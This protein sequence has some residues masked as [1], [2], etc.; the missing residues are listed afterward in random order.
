MNMGQVRQYQEKLKE[1]K[2]LKDAAKEV[3]ADA[4]QLM[5]Q[6]ITEME[7][8]GMQS[9]KNDVGTV[10]L[11]RD[12]YASAAGMEAVEA[13][14]AAELDSLLGVQTGKLK[15]L[16]REYIDRATELDPLAGIDEAL[17][18]FYAEHPSLKDKISVS[19]GYSL[20]TRKA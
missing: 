17:G 10:Y 18:Q 9:V 6:I 8:D 20:G 4:D 15:S 14:K 1:L 16:V 3:K 7:E 13:V 5:A 11:K 19:E 2:T 12:I